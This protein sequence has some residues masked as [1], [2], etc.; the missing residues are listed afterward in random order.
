MIRGSAD[1]LA[2]KREAALEQRID[3]YIE[4]MAAA[5][6]RKADGYLNTYTQ[7]ERP[8]QPWGTNGGD[9]NVQH[10]VYNA[11]A[12]VEAAVHYYRATG[13]TR[14]LQVATRLANHMADVMGPPPKKNV[15]PGHSLAEEAFVKLYRLFREQPDLKT[16]WPF[17]V[18]EERYLR[19]AEFWIENRGQPAG[20]KSFGTYGQDHLPFTRMETIEGHAVRATLFCAGMAAI[21]AVNH[22]P[23]YLTTAQ[24]LWKNMVTRRMYLVGGLGAVAGIEGFGADYALPNDGY[25]ETCAA[26][27]AGFFH[28]NMNLLFAE[29][30]YVDELER[31]LYNG[32]LSGVSLRGDT[33]FYENPQEAGRNRVRWSWHGCPCCPPM[34]LKVMGALP[35]Y[36]YATDAEGVYV[37]L[38]VGSQARMKVAGADL[39]LKQTTRYPWEGRVQLLVDVPQPATFA[40]RVRIPGWCTGARVTL[41]GA[42]QSPLNPERGYAVFRRTW[43][44][45]D[46]LELALPMPVERIHAHPRVQANAGRV[47]LQRGPM[48]YCL[49]GV[50]QEEARRVHQLVIP[51]DTAIRAEH[52]ADLLGGVTVLRGSAIALRKEPWP[53]A[54]YLPAERRPGVVPTEFTAIPYF[55]N[56]NRDACELIVWAAESM[57]RA[58]PAPRPT[59]ADEARASASHC[60]R[61]DSVEA[62]NDQVEPKHSAD[63]SIPRFTWWDHRGTGEWVQYDFRRA[64]TVSAVAVYWWDERSIQ[65]HCRVPQSWRLLYR[66]GQEWIPVRGAGAFGT[67]IDQFNQVRFTPVETTA[68]RLEVQLQPEWSG[69]VLEWKVE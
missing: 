67:A 18:D 11:G 21:G 22:R 33:Y 32:I 49:E 19:L 23:E 48:V 59:L 16:Q 54:L 46:T 1:F 10:D 62:L 29:S 4:R 51:A 2:A 64:V 37:N 35:G 25:L 55:A 27:G 31:G 53:D 24:R 6:A 56:A 39:T 52:R 40:L 7:M 9:D 30:R 38:F 14:L 34:F 36:L 20:R 41:N 68:L 47:A 57:E 45:G 58:T 13:K 43:R 12:M 17:P 3:G 50:D 15:V 61:S 63:E 65:R 26:I 69:G 60:H 66:Q 44:S 8:T 42:E 28:H 5:Q